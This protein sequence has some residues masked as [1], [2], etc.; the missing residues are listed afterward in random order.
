MILSEITLTSGNLYAIIGSLFGGALT[1]IGLIGLLLRYIW[2][3]RKKELDKD[4]EEVKEA[5]EKADNRFLDHSSHVTGLMDVLSANMKELMDTYH[6]FMS[7]IGD[8]KNEQLSID[9]KMLALQTDH[10]QT[11][12]EVKVLFK[13][14][15]ENKEAIKD[16][17]NRIDDKLAG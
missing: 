9:R 3:V 8:M 17:N 10:N 13:L 16:T 14:H 4:I 7:E 11:K 12:K 1:L 15:S 2:N 6:L 5:Q